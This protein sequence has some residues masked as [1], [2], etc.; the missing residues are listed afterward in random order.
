MHKLINKLFFKSV[1]FKFTIFVPFVL[2]YIYFCIYLCISAF[3]C[4]Y[5]YLFLHFCVR[6]LVGGPNLSQ[7][8]IG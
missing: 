4:F 7:C 5:I 3:I 1:I 6:M 8:R 2:Y